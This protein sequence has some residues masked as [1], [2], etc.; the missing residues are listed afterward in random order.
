MNAISVTDAAYPKN[1]VA[2]EFKGVGK[3]FG[4]VQANRDISFELR[5]GEVLAL[6]G[7]NGSGK[8][9]LMNMLAGIYFPDE[10]HIY[11][12]GKL[13]SI[14][15]PKD[16]YDLRIGMVHQHFKL[17][18]IFTALQNIALGLKNNKYSSL[19]KIRADVGEICAR[20]GFNIDLN[21]KV[22]DMSVSEKQTLEIIKVL[23]RGAD[24]LVLDEPTAVLTPQETQKLFAVIRNMRRDGKSIIIITHKLAEVM[25]ISDRVAILRKGEYVGTIETAE[26]DQRILTEMMVGKKVDLKID[27]PVVK[28]DRPLLEIRNLRVKSDDGSLAI[29]DASFYIRGGEILGVAGITGCGQKE[30]CE[31]IAGLRRIESGFIMHKGESIVGLSPKAIIEKGVSMSFIPEDRL[32]MGLVPSMSITDNMM[33]KTFGDR[34]F[35]I[36]AIK[37]REKDDDFEK[38]IK[39]TINGVS[40]WINGL[41]PFVDRKEARRRAKQLIERLEISTPSSETPVRQLSGGNVQKVLVGREIESSPNVIVTAY[42]VRG[43]D[44][45]SSYVI[46][47]ILNE[48]KKRGTGILF[49][50]EDLDVMMAL[51]DKIMVLC[52]GKVMGV[53]HA[54]KTTKEDLGLMMTGSKDLVSEKKDKKLGKAKDSNLSEEQW[55]AAENAEEKTEDEH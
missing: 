23:F 3:V 29:D 30:L 39:K 28:I 46:Y 25:E 4:T 21:K 5:R 12:N 10:G 52:H 16:A 41:C 15:T 22:Y 13:A 34:K 26:A 18:D 17:V 19:K 11:V 43:L 42:P 45:N 6:L 49:V 37:P 47:D 48:Q 2:V 7:E 14:K 50:G 53:V 32:G 38:I 54:D 40:G 20:Y 55:Q 9:T 35:H 31:A 8:T 36:P 24:I 27:R 44:I 1:A 33:L 51:C